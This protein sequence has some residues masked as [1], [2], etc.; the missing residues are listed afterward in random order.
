MTS[1]VAPLDEVLR[2]ENA[3]V[4]HRFS[5]DHSISVEDSLEIFHETK[6]WLW[7]C[8]RHPDLGLPLF[9]EARAIDEMWHTFLLFTRDY[10]A[11][12]EKS[13][14]AFVHHH[15]RTKREADAWNERARQDPAGTLAERKATLKRAY[16]IVADELGTD[17]LVKWCEE[18]PARFSFGQ[19]AAP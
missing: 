5:A 3:E 8:A 14:G 9:S 6:K 15:P 7:L 18:F 11:F 17:T 10:A 19:A 1:G 2:Y 13:F 12:C 4:V 16:E